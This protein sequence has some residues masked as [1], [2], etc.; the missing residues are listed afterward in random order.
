MR[1]R[2]YTYT[3]LWWRSEQRVASPSTTRNSTGRCQCNAEEMFWWESIPS[4]NKQSWG[5]LIYST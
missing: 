2:A 3:R 5:T 4:V 1:E